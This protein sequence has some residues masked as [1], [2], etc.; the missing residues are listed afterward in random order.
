MVA[1]VPFWGATLHRYAACPDGV[2]TAEVSS[3]MVSPTI[4]NTDG[5]V[6]DIQTMPLTRIS[7]EICVHAPL[8]MLPPV[9]PVPPAPPLPPLPP[10]PPAPPEPPLPA[11][12]DVS[13][14]QA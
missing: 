7:P 14:L 4:R 8:H 6:S 13:K 2:H 10:T 12:P 1:E 9:P 3:E 5:I 11:V